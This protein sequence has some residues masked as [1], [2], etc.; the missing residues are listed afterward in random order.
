MASGPAVLAMFGFDKSFTIPFAEISMSGMVG[1]L[2]LNDSGTLF[3]TDVVVLPT[4]E[5]FGVA[6]RSP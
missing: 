6:V 3:P 5:Q 4:L 1:Y 2:P